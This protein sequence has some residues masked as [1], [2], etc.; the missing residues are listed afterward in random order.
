MGRLVCGVMWQ[1]RVRMEE[2]MLRLGTREIAVVW[3]CRT[4][5]TE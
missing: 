1:D 5:G 4:K 2:L 3:S